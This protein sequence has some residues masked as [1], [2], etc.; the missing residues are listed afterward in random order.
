MR[1][2]TTEDVCS[3]QNVGD[4]SEQEA[5]VAS[6]SESVHERNSLKTSA[7]SG[8]SIK[9][10]DLANLDHFNG[11]VEKCSPRSFLL[12]VEQNLLQ[13]MNISRSQ[14]LMIFRRL[15]TGVAR[16]WF[17]DHSK[18]FKNY[19]QFKSAFSEHFQSDSVLVAQL[20][21]LR[22]QRFNPREFKSVTEF[23]WTQVERFRNLYSERLFSV[24]TVILEIMP[25]LPSRFRQALF[26]RRFS[27]FEEYGQIINY[28]E[29]QTA[30]CDRQNG[31]DICNN[32]NGKKSGLVNRNEQR[33][34]KRYS[35]H[36]NWVGDKRDS[37]GRST[38]SFGNN[39]RSRS[40]QYSQ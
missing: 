17:D 25:N 31:Q 38:R 15:L 3:R 1:N 18:K 35:Q 20:S 26:G 13:L 8:N 33:D 36:V 19:A 4:I 22:S 39:G 40:P 32:N 6:D 23:Y 27:N 12:S 11:N 16:I 29:V 7:R 28:L 14:Y 5:G 9:L 21:I 24:D 34:N 2:R 30:F 37:Y 10:S